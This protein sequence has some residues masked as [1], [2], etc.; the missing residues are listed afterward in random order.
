MTKKRQADGNIVKK[1]VERCVFR[2][3]NLVKI[4]NFVEYES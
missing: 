3:S 2:V 4:E 1:K